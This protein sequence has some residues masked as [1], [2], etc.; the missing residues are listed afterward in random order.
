MPQPEGGCAMATWASDFEAS[1][2]YDCTGQG[3][4]VNPNDPTQER[5]TSYAI[6]R[7][8]TVENDP[9]FVPSPDDTG[10][11]L[12]EDDLGQ[13]FV[14]VYA[15]DE[16]G[17]YDYCTTYIE[18]EA[19]QDCGDPTVGNLSGVIVREG[20]DV[21]VEFVE[22][23]LNGGMTATMTTAADGAYG[24]AGVTAGGDYTV[25][26][27]RNDDHDNGVTTFDI[28]LINKH[29]LGTD[30]LDTPY[31]RIAADVNRSE[32][33]TTL[34][35]IQ[36]RK[37]ILNIDTE[38]ANNTSW[39][40]VE[41]GYTFP[42]VENPWAEAFPEL[43]NVNNLNGVITDADFVAIKVGDV[44]SSAR[45]NSLEDGGRSLN[46][47]FDL[48]MDEQP[49]RSGNTYTIPVY[50]SALAQIS[51]YQGTLQLQ[52]VQLLDILYG[53]VEATHFGLQYADQGIIT[54]S[55][56][57]AAVETQTPASPQDAESP[58][59]S[60][61]LRATA[62]QPLSE[63]LSLSSRYTVAEAYSLGGEHRELGLSF[64]TA[65][66][67]A[68]QFELYQNTANPFQGET[69]IGFRLPVDSEV[70]LTI[71]DVSGRVL[72][73]VRGDY[74]AGYNTINLTSQQLGGV[75]GVLNYTLTA[76]EHTATRQM[77]IL[78]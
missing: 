58:L 25:T 40:F 65:A 18:V 16:E 11:I 56:N 6:Y 61:V 54:M 41:A 67:L 27:F 19:H 31:K 52:G 42:D 37:L 72:M 2:I 39:R 73:I 4:E 46:G 13:T 44:N 20:D 78:E 36:M 35:I 10:L 77:V 34:D 23:S 49:L 33:I 15:F 66:A 5:V 3:P 21:T 29:I 22:V 76:G 1:P 68:E 47:S 70:M 12:T 75:T 50:A 59:F 53:E 9:D 71:S 24:F 45:A 7:Q 63:A 62:D 28:V 55:W 43:Y 64:R 51:G 60:L 69:L 8:T 48:E 32:T 17:N 38:F 57:A 14:Y 26:P 30:L 74:A